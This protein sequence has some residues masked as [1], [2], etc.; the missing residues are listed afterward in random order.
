[1][2]SSSYFRYPHLHDDLI[3]FVAEDD[4]WLAPISGGR[5]WRVSSMGLQARN[6][7]FSPD[8]RTLAWTVVQGSAPEA[9]AASVD[10][11][12]Y[13]QLS[14]FGNASTKVRG[15]TPDGDVLVTSSFE[16][17]D[18]RLAWAYALPLDGSEHQQ[19]PY[20]PVETVA[21]GPVIGDE[22]PV[23]L[24]SVL[25]RE[26]AWWKRYRGGTAGKLWLD[27]DGSG[28]FERLLSDLDGNLTDAMWIGDR[29]AFLSDHEGY[30]NVYSVTAA[31]N[32]LRRHTDHE[33]F[34]VRHASTDGARVVFES[35]G[36]LFVMD[37]LNSEPVQLAITLGSASTGRRPRLANA[38]AHL[39][40]V[41]PD[42]TG[43][44]STVE[45][46]GT[47][48]WLT[49]REGPA[50]VIEST[51]G[52]RARLARPLGDDHAIYVADHDQVEALY[53][54]STGPGT[55]SH[56]PRE[57][58]T[59]GSAKTDPAT[60]S[61]SA[62]SVS[63]EEGNIAD[64]EAALPAPVSAA[65]V[66]MGPSGGVASAVPATADKPASASQNSSASDEDAD[67]SATGNAQSTDQ[68]ASKDAQQNADARG[69]AR[70]RVELPST[71]RVANIVPSPDGTAA[72]ISTEYG[73]VYLLDVAAG[74]LR[75]ITSHMAGPVTEMAFSPDSAWLV[76]TDPLTTD[77]DRSKLRL[78]NVVDGDPVDLTD[79]RFP[80]FSPQFTPDGRFVAFLSRRTFDPVYDTH[81]F[82]LS[83]PSSTKPYLIPLAAST[84]SPFGA[85]VDGIAAEP[86]NLSQDASN[87]TKVELDG[88]GQR[89]ITV[90]V[91]AGNYEHLRAADGA[92]LWLAGDPVGTTGDGLA[93]TDTKAPKQRIERFDVATR[94]VSTLVPAAKAF[95]LSG[96]GKRMAVIDDGVVRVLPVAAPVDEKS[97]DN[98]PVDL[99]RIRIRLDPLKVWGQAFDE[100]WRLQRDFFWAEDMAGIDWQ[101]VYDRYRPLVEKLG[102]SD[103]LADLLWELHG[104]LGTSHAYV[105]PK[106]IVEAGG[107]KQGL[108]GAE[109]KRTAAGWA[110]AKVLPGETSDSQARSPLAGPGV[111]IRVGDI[112][113]AV[114]GVAVPASG[115][116]SLLVG[117][118]DK[119]VELTVQN[120]PEHAQPG[121]IRH[122]AVLPV[123]NEERL[124]YQAWVATNR[125]TVRDASEGSFGY[126]HV[127]DMQ[128]RGWAQLHRD[129]DTETAKDGLI[130]DIRRNRGGH[131]SQLV[132]ELI[133]RK[134][135]AWS[136]G[137]GHQPHIYPSQAPRGPVVIITDEFAG[138]DG[139]IVTQVSKLR[140]IGPVIGMR[141]WGGVVGIDG[142]FALADGTGVT[143]PR[144]AYWFSGGVGWDVENYGVDP[145]IEVPFPPHAYAAAEDPQ[146]EYGVG[147]LKEMV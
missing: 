29:L 69:T 77:S 2:T 100:T 17:A 97:Q 47:V 125:A 31:G 33:G 144:Y 12:D 10:G 71:T 75:E 62:D 133:G 104:E 128:A 90:P 53:I 79:G 93:S 140:G 109:L 66:N 70:R 56:T 63:P 116:A 105:Q 30:G 117:A 61:D 123:Q 86:D 20:G 22:R 38:A 23:L 50:R 135:T 134:M 142:R 137:R 18:S 68:V 129:L 103:D 124:R 111:D 6:P 119:V 27:A 57:A 87:A 92:F 113:L 21:F 35:A 121:L 88:I 8:G 138:S 94:A 91:K 115:P 131:T 4:V 1:M 99:S 34:Y 7:R 60:V 16:E 19:L 143:Q 28:E 67:A 78:V 41:F 89:I 73:Q 145:D 147:V 40:E 139:D 58:A 108:L 9:V 44:A 48:H 122:V 49:H 96:N 72:A 102:S 114:D 101:G 98:V 141:T 54:A 84:P 130:V 24:S 43:R 81:A 25:S 85:S 82:D 95:Q 14:Y 126:L 146:L 64:T 36:N 132:A 51:P 120:S 5:A 76:Y 55:G 15:F 80:D 112:L 37:S 118:A 110:V 3:T 45:V 32:D 127:P 26:P 42:Q 52:A 46:H 136:V 106:L 59:A 74:S 107:A 11:G 65:G 39:G 13:R 83:F